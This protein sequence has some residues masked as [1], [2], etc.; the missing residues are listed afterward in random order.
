MVGPSRSG[1]GGR[2][3]RK[4]A[5]VAEQGVTQ[6]GEPAGVRVRDGTPQGHAA[7]DPPQDL[8]L[9]RPHPRRAKAAAVVDLPAPAGPTSATATP[10]T[11]TALACRLTTP[12]SRSTRPSTGPRR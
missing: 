9:A 6:L 3:G 5:G 2:D 8:E 7:D 12:R 11:A 10:P 1:S 4:V